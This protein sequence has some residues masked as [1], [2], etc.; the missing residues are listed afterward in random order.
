MTNLM[1][2]KTDSSKNLIC[3]EEITTSIKVQLMKSSFLRA[4]KNL[5][6]WRKDTYNTSFSLMLYTL[7]NKADDTNKMKIFV[8]FPEE[9][10]CYLLW[11][12]NHEVTEKN[13]FDKWLKELNNGE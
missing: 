8:G 9:T 1:I 6:Y 2:H 4:M 12:T 13:F 11:Y 7:I 3:F 10:I 5:Y